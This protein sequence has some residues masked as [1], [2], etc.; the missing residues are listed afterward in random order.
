[1]GEDLLGAIADELD[2]IASWHTGPRHLRVTQLADKVRAASAGQTV[3]PNDVAAYTLPSTS[4]APQ[5]SEDELAELAA[6]EAEG[7]K[8]PPA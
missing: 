2:A 6:L 1:M 7:D 8:T 5:Y 4:R 3:D